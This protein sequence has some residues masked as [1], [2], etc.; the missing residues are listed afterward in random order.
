MSEVVI[1]LFIVKINEIIFDVLTKIHIQSFTDKYVKSSKII[2]W[3]FI[4]IY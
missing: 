4:N 3:N 2:N 1:L